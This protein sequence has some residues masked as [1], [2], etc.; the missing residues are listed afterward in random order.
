MVKGMMKKAEMERIIAALSQ[1]VLKAMG[2]KNL[3]IVG[4]RKRGAILAERIAK[5]IEKITKTEI[6]FGALDITLY[7]DDLSAIGPQPIVHRTEIPF[8]LTKKKVLLI[9]DVLYTGRTIRAALDELIDFGRPAV[10]KLLVLVDR[11]N[12]ELPIQPD[13]VGKKVMVQKNEMVEVKLK[14]SD[15]KEEVIIIKK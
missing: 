3:V 14:E 12:R 13:F 8:D 9:D 6:L 15:G 4:I 2:E 1:K 7:R 5:K 11:N 10:I